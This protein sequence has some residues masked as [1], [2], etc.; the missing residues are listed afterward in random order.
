MTTTHVT[1][2][3]DRIVAA[4]A[5]GDTRL[6]SHLRRAQWHGDWAGAVHDREPS[7]LA[8]ALGAV[9]LPVDT[10]EMARINPAAVAA[11]LGVRGA[12][13]RILV[14]RSLSLD[15]RR[16]AIAHEC[17]HVV[18]A[19]D[20]GLEGHEVQCDLWA[21]AFLGE[22]AEP[23]LDAGTPTATRARISPRSL[24]VVGRPL[25]PSMRLPRPLPE[26]WCGT[27]STSA[28]A[29][30]GGGMGVK[31]LQGVSSQTPPASVFCAPMIAPFFRE[32]AWRTA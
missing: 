2:A 20:A 21:L 22:R 16:L 8:Q 19:A 29:P 17:A 26:I 31:S 10:A 9:V 4:A 30:L 28:V 27:M 6:A 11:V 12:Q 18:L 3:M 5:R 13:P 24:D 25:A 14:L 23:A 1:A 32:A 15:E 7:R